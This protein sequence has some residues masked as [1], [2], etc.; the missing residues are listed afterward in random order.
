MLPSIEGGAV[1][2]FCL[3]AFRKPHRYGLLTSL[4]VEEPFVRV[5]EPT[6]M[7]PPDENSSASGILG[8][9]Y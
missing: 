4:E 3:T 5:D 2:L 1:G 6:A 8:R 7:L 9:W